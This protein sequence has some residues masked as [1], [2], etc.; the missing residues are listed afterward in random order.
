MASNIMRAYSSLDTFDKK[1]VVFDGPVDALWIENMNTVLDDS[2]TLCLSNGERVKLKPQMR[3][4]FEVMDLAV[5][6]PATVSRCGM[7]YL[8]D[9]VVGYAAIV[10]KEC[11]TQLK[12]VLADDIIAHLQLQILAT[13]RKSV[14][15]LRKRTKQL[16]AVGEVQ[17]AVSIVRVIKM[18]VEYFSGVLKS[19][20]RD[21]INK[22]HLEKMFVWTFIWVLGSTVTSETVEI[23][24][25]IVAETF[26]V[27]ALPR[28]SGMDYVIRI[29]KQDGRVDVEYEPWEDHI[30]SFVYDKSMS[31]F[32]M[33]VQ[34]K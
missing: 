21:E 17:L 24:E 3:M 1:W 7:V 14:A 25:K 10:D 15:N 12:D 9:L 23:F 31:Y 11:A 33:V 22:K 19:P 27:D 26:P 16:I 30:P 18:I 28:G 5:A 8:D 32:D 34:T 6:S 29:T 2:M 13:F 4:L 20:L